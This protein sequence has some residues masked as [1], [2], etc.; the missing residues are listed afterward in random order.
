MVDLVHADHELEVAA[1][2]PEG[3]DVN[4]G[5][6]N[7]HFTDHSSE[8]ETTVA[9]LNL[10]NEFNFFSCQLF[11]LLRRGIAER[12]LFLGPWGLQFR[13]TKNVDSDIAHLLTDELFPREEH[14]A[15]L[16]QGNQ[17]VLLVFQTRKGLNPDLDRL[18]IIHKRNALPEDALLLD[19]LGLNRASCIECVPEED[20][21]LGGLEPPL[22]PACGVVLGYLLFVRNCFLDDL[23]GSAALDHC[24]ETAV[25]LFHFFPLASEDQLCCV[26][27]LSPPEH[28]LNHM[29]SL[30]L[31]GV[32][33]E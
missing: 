12:R 5:R 30:H 6:V 22:D 9:P 2:L 24:G 11:E 16:W 25:C 13:D 17:K 32:L 18:L 4:R 23:S 33:L 7:K 27:E 26:E 15:V 20:P 3:R 14:T 29:K 10:H 19:C 21:E 8:L 1:S 28:G 31:D